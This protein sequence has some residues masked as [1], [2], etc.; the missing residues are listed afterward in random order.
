MQIYVF[1]DVMFCRWVQTVA[2]VPN[3][4]N[5][6]IFTVKHSKSLSLDCFI[7]TKKTQF[8]FETSETIH[9]TTQ[10]NIPEDGDTAVRTLSS[11][12][13]EFSRGWTGG[14]D[15]NRV[16]WLFLL[17]SRADP[18]HRAVCQHERTIGRK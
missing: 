5:T 6:L 17:N 3:D 9:L 11:T 16:F 1:W 10:H 4:R 13:A 2:D 15:I 7:L 14:V 12:T 18:L 8:S